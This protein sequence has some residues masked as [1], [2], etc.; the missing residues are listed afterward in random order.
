[1][2]QSTKSN[3][4]GSTSNNAG[5][6]SNSNGNG[7]KPKATSVKPQPV[8]S[9]LSEDEQIAAL[10]A[11]LP[12]AIAKFFTVALR[13]RDQRQSTKVGYA[14]RE[15][16]GNDLS[17][18]LKKNGKTLDWTRFNKF[19]AHVFGEPED[20]K[21]SP[22]VIAALM[23]QLFD[24]FSLDVDVAIEQLVEVNRESLDRR[25]R[26]QQRQ[27]EFDDE[28]DDEFEGEAEDE[29]SDELDEEIM[30]QLDDNEFGEDE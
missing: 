15:I 3:R 10:T 17:A 7:A 24:R 29:L 1:M 28:F 14:A 23:A 25:N 16:L 30:D 21:Y 27:D 22:R 2:T 19:F 12:L 6:R 8:L 11:Q 5:H 18:M 26:Q 20:L 9:A 4:N 13:D